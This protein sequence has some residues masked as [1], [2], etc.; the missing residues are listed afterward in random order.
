MNNIIDKF[1]AQGEKLSGSRR[2]QLNELV[3]ELHGELSNLAEQDA[4]QAAEV[5]ARVDRLAADKLDNPERNGE[6]IPGLAELEVAHP[7]IV[8]IVNRIC[9]MLADIG[10]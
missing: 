4:G 6:L 8:D 9:K 5:G 2:E 10:I 7:K 3:D 1:K